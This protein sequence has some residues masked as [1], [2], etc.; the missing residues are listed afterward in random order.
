[1]R[2]DSV[3]QERPATGVAPL[4]FSN[5]ESAEPEGVAVPEKD[6]AAV[7]SPSFQAAAGPEAAAS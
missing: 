4:L 3:S 6:S 2:D 1:M 7:R 5:T